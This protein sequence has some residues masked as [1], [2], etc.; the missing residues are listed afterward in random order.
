MQFQLPSNLQTQLLAYDPTLK[1][2][3]QQNKP[4]TQTKKA[5]YPL[6]NV[7][8][9]IPRE[10]MPESIHQDATNH[11]NSVGVADRY[12]LF[13]RFKD[14]TLVPYAI[15][16]HFEQC[17]YA[18]WLPPKGQED[19]YLY[20]YAVAFKDTEASAKVVPNR[21]WNQRHEFDCRTVGRSQIYYHSRLINKY[22]VRNGNEER[23]WRAPGV[24]SYYQKARSISEAIGQF[25]DQLRVTIP[26]WQDTRNMFD[27][28]RTTCIADALELR[29]PAYFNSGAVN[30]EE[31]LPSAD[32]FFRIVDYY[33]N[34]SGYE[35]C[36][37]KDVQRIRH[38]IDKPFFRRWIQERCDEAIK[39]YN[40]PD[41][42][43]ASN[44]RAPWK[45]IAHL[46]YSINSVNALWPDAPLDYYQTN[47]DAML[48]IRLRQGANE[49][50]VAWLK[51]H[52]HVASYFN[53]LD[54][55]YRAA[56]KEAEE[57]KYGYIFDSDYID[58]DQAAREVENLLQHPIDVKKTFNFDP[59][60]LEQC[61]IKNCCAIGVSAN[62]VEPLEASSIGTTIQQAFLLMH[63]I[64]RYDDSVI[65]NYNKSVTDIMENIRDFICLHYITDNQSTEFWKDL[66]SIQIP[67]TLRSKLELWKHRLPIRE[68]YNNLSDYILFREPN[69]IMV[70]DGLDLFDRESI[71]A[72]YES[73]QNSIK[74]QAN[75]IVSIHQQGDSNL[76]TIPH[77]AFIKLIREYL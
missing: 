13:T 28:I 52:M 31:W 42:T 8:D 3:A 19:N 35:G 55:Y 34:Q 70:M 72:E 47:L 67:D 23:H 59:G 48:N 24:A 62:F 56:L 11:I 76:N 63:R 33:F 75:Q 20:G 38:I 15:L 7:K 45:Q 61:W 6:G 2:L 60:A 71:R 22:D 77:K 17:W 66:K 68:D 5:K 29:L 27:R 12:Q 41:N 50:A 32:N 25:E 51:Q 57:R 9:L 53:M 64:S 54:K 58:A 44:I 4:K 39:Q 49:L 69:F 30:K 43:H 1:K 18:A 21:F 26:T 36:E 37:Y 46:C 73:L 14:Q 10:I 16:Y 65:K 74:Q 40:D